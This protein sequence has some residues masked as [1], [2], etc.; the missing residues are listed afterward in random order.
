[1]RVA[2]SEGYATYHGLETSLTHR[3][4]HGLSVEANY[5]WAK[6]IDNQTIVDLYNLPINKGLS[7]FHIAHRYMTNG[8]WEVPYGP[9]RRF[10]SAAP[11]VV[12]AILG[13]CYTQVPNRLRDP[14]LPGDQRTRGRFF[15]TGSFER[16]P[17]YVVGNAGKN[18]LIDPATATWTSPS[19]SGSR[20]PKRS[21]SSFAPSCSTP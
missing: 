14:N 2:M 1:M 19:P 4:H 11:S 15:D 5:T 21:T 3:F 9:G 18:I 12:H 6:T 10:G 13:G 17:L 8:V 20:W 16:P 7:N